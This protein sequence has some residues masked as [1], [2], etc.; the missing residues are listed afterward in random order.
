VSVSGDAIVATAIESPVGRLVAGATRDGVCLLEFAE[1]RRAERQRAAIAARLALPIVAGDHEHLTALRDELAA[2]FAGTLRH[3]TVPLVT[4]GSPFEDR[5]WQ[6]LR[7]IPYGGTRSYEA[8]ALAIGEP[9]TA[10]RAVGG[11]NGANPI[12]IVI[13][14]HRVI[15][16]DGSLGGYGGGSWRKQRLLA[17]ERGERS[18]F[19][20]PLGAPGAH[21]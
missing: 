15:A 20:V 6:A 19:A 11:A 2:Y 18:L 13:P 17:L 21:R 8:L 1:G 9:A 3:F 7:A 16:K 10:A 4:R 5:V 12:A 14:C